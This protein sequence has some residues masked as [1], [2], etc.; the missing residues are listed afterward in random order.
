V[1][2]FNFFPYQASQTKLSIENKDEQSIH[3]KPHQGI[4]NKAFTTSESLPEMNIIQEKVP[5]DLPIDIPNDT[6]Q[7]TSNKVEGNRTFYFH[8]YRIRIIFI[9]RDASIPKQ[10]SR[11]RAFLVTMGF[12]FSHKLHYFTFII[13]CKIHE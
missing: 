10:N 4:S 5:P 12:F 1:W 6:E 11:Q 13:S 9:W 7:S 2:I 3:P 8:F